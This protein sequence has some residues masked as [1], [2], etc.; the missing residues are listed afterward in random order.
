MAALIYW[1]IGKQESESPYVHIHWLLAIIY[2]FSGK[3]GCVAVFG[4]PGT[5][6]AFVGIWNGFVTFRTR[7]N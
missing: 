5:L 1:Y 2:G 7:N 4:L 3:W 6:F